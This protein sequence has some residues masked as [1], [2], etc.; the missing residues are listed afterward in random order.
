ML[1]TLDEVD[2]AGLHAFPAEDETHLGP[3]DEQRVEAELIAR[4][5]ERRERDG[6]L[7]CS[8][9][10][11][12]IVREVYARELSTK[13]TRRE[14]RAIGKRFCAKRLFVLLQA[15]IAAE[16]AEPLTAGRA[17][18]RIEHSG[19]EV[20]VDLV[21]AKAT[22]AGLSATVEYDALVNFAMKAAW[23]G[24][25]SGRLSRCVSGSLRRT[26]ARDIDHA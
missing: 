20:S 25:S 14:A 2:P 9:E 1:K 13:V 16:A 21:P 15:A 19:F 4:R 11:A 24:G 23:P 18:L 10:L 12:T 5:I 26:P 7:I 17:T 22:A 6:K 3:A 8:R